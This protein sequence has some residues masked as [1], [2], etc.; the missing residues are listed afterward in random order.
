MQRHWSKENR[1]FVTGLFQCVQLHSLLIIA[2]LQPISRK[3][4]TPLQPVGFCK[5]QDITATLLIHI[6]NREE[7]HKGE[8]EA[9]VIRFA[10]CLNGTHTSQKPAYYALLTAWTEHTS[11]GMWLFEAWGKQTH[12]RLGQSWWPC[13]EERW[14]LS[15]HQK[16][17]R[18]H[19]SEREK[20]QTSTSNFGGNHDCT[21]CKKTS[22]KALSCHLL[23]RYG[24]CNKKTAHCVW[25][26]AWREVAGLHDASQAIKVSPFTCHCLASKSQHHILILTCTLAYIQPIF[27][28]QQASQTPRMYQLRCTEEFTKSTTKRMK[29]TQVKLTTVSFS[30]NSFVK[31]FTHQQV[32]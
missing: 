4:N 7:L 28:H 10:D 24:P 1:T 30:W 31:M 8:S 12:L 27:I 6:G 15:P 23:L 21:F 19:L 3:I 22:W 26:T 20:E 25:K 5:I 16:Q 2:L 17:A 29:Q 9:S 18:L 13:W 14:R 32:Q 11:I